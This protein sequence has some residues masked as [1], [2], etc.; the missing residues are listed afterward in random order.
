M[1]TESDIQNKIYS[2]FASVASS[3]GY[4]PLHGKII[5]VLLVKNRPISL[6]DLAKET[7]YSPSML[8]SA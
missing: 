6:Q 2:T 8:S 4:S 5:G 3:I 1:S 7:G